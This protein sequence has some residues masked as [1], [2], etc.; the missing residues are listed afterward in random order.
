VFW[1]GSCKGVQTLGEYGIRNFYNREDEGGNY[2]T[3]QRERGGGIYGGEEDEYVS[4]F[5]F[6]IYARTLKMEE[7]CSSDISMKLGAYTVEVS[8]FFDVSELY[9]ATI[10]RLE[11]CR[12]FL[13]IWSFTQRVQKNVLTL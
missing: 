3:E 5:E 11:L 10:I 12:V 4:Y 2:V 7:V 9:S 13:C 6:K 1:G 8:S